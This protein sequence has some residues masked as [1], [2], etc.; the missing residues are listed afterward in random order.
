MNVDLKLQHDLPLTLK[1]AAEPLFNM[2]YEAL[3]NKFGALRAQGLPFVK[4]GR[5]Y[6]LYP[7]HVRAWRASR[8]TADAKR[9]LRQGGYECSDAEKMA[10][11]PGRG[12]SATP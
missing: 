5:C 7:S 9:A 4:E 8:Y 3:R 6:L 11:R 1:E 10:S 2:T 12:T